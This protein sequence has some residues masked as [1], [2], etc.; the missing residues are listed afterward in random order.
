MAKTKLEE[1]MERGKRLAKSNIRVEFTC[2]IC[3][4]VASVY[5]ACD[6]I[7]CECHACGAWKEE[8]GKW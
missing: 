7:R 3:K 8:R 1:M 2:P 5:K 6:V 4:G